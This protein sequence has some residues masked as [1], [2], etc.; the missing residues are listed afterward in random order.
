MS[1]MLKGYIWAAGFAGIGYVLFRT[2]GRDG[3]MDTKELKRTEYDAIK[4]QV[5]DSVYAV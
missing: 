5:R 3:G 4:Q 2:I 1:H